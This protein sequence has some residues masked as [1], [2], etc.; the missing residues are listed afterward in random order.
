MHLWFLHIF[1]WLDHGLI[2]LSPFL[3]TQRQ[4]T[5]DFLILKF[6]FLF[7]VLYNIIM[8]VMSYGDIMGRG[9][10]GAVPKGGGNLGGSLGIL[11]FSPWKQSRPGQAGLFSMEDHRRSAL[12]VYTVLEPTVARTRYALHG[13]SHSALPVSPF[14]CG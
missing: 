13:P 12:T 8:G 4:Q 2:I 6:P 7:A 10:Y 1:S 3:L 11:S 9:L 14:L 5:K